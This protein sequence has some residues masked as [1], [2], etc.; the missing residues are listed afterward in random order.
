VRGNGGDPD[1]AAF[2]EA[3]VNIYEPQCF[4]A[5][6]QGGPLYEPLLK[7]I[8][9]QPEAARRC[10]MVR[11]REAKLIVRPHGQSELYNYKSDPQERENIYGESGAASLQAQLQQRLLHWYINTTGVPPFDRDQ[12]NCP[13]FYA[14]GRRAPG[15]AAGIA[16]WMKLAETRKSE[17]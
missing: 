13:P 16:G 2:A 11:T 6:F 10:A 8:N 3:G 14:S 15:M 4:Q 9:E 17:V 5:A 7:L 12:R 1:R